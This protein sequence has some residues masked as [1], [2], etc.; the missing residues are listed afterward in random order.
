MNTGKESAIQKE[1]A[2]NDFF[3]DVLLFLK[4][5]GRDPFRLTDTGNLRLTDIHSLGE[6]FALDIY[7]PSR[8]LYP[9][10]NLRRYPTPF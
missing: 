1:I 2:A 9:R 10:H 8:E 7:R 4:E 5:A 6:H 3:H